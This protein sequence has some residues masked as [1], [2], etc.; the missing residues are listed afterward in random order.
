MKTARP[1]LGTAA[2]LATLFAT[3]AATASGQYGAAMPVAGET[4]A[5]ADAIAAV[6]AE[7]HFEGKVRGR[8]TE[9]CRK[10]GCFMILTDDAA[11][12]RVTFKDYGFFVPTDTGPGMSTV[13]GALSF[14][15]LS[16]EEADHYAADAGRPASSDRSL[17][18]YGIIA[19]AVE[20]E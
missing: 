15:E 7:G 17:R 6:E 4:F 1:L 20:I 16:P 11:Y 19:T 14:V 18:E 5:L 9:V 12:A 8:I 13:Y 10:K 3:S 2:L